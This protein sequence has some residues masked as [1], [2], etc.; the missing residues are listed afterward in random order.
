MNNALL[1]G[2][3]VKKTAL[4]VIFILAL[5]LSSAEIVKIAKAN[6]LPIWWR[7]FYTSYTEVEPVSG[8]IPPSISIFNPQN[9][10]DYSSN[11]ITVSLRVRNAELAGWQSSIT[12]INY[13]LD[14]KHI[15]GYFHS[16][17][18][19][20]PV[21]ETVFSMSSLSS[22]KHR[23]IVEAIVDVL[24]SNPSEVFTLTSSSTIIFTVDTIP[25]EISITSVENK[26]YFTSDLQLNFTVNEVFYNASY[27][28]D[29][30]GVAVSENLTLSDLPVGGHSLTVYA[31]DRAGNFGAS[32]TIAFATEPFPTTLVVASVL[33]VAVVA[34]GLLVYF[35]KRHR[36]KSA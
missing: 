7:L 8:T 4:A 27:V 19:R 9:N 18:E 6:A 36:L 14:G 35:K 3:A 13:F 24:K 22:G 11:N 15:G 5:L 28:L 10:T 34:I 2:T 1:S 31:Y 20:L 23:L 26:T 21:F 33:V 29:G 32:A 30:Q 17:G 25:P 16:I 12:N